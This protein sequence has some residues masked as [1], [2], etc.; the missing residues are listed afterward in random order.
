MAEYKVLL[1]LNRDGTRETWKRIYPTVIPPAVGDAVVL[2]DRPPSEYVPGVAVASRAWRIDGSA[3]IEL[4]TIP[5]RDDHVAG[6][7]GP[8]VGTYAEFAANL[9]DAGWERVPAGG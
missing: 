1:T 2:W 5:F 6:F 4:E 8:P 3:D 9:L 7:E